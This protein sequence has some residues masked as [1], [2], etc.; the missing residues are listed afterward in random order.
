[1]KVEM[2]KNNN[3]KNRNKKFKNTNRS[4]NNINYINNAKNTN[5]NIKNKEKDKKKDKNKNNN[6]KNKNKNKK[7][8][9][10]N[11]SSNNN[12]FGNLKDGI[13]KRAKKEISRLDKNLSDIYGYNRKRDSLEEKQ[14]IK[15]SEENLSVENAK[16][17]NL[18]REIEKGSDSKYKKSFLVFFMFVL[19]LSITLQLKTINGVG[20]K[21]KVAALNGEMRNTLLMQREKNEMLLKEV[22]SKE[23]ELSEL[24]DK[25]SKN[26][27]KFEEKKNKLNEN[28]KKL[29]HTKIA[30]KGIVIKLRDG[31]DNKNTMKQDIS[32]LI[33]HDSDIIAIVNILR[34]AG[35]EAI[36]VNDQ[37]I[38]TKTPISCIGTVIKINE[39]KVGSP[40]IISAIGN[41][42]Y[43]ESA[44]TMPGG[45]IELLEQYGIDIS[46]EK[47]NNIEIP[48]YL[49]SSKMEY[50]K[51]EK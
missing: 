48:A 8:E 4:V 15:L 26:S 1:M 10:K 45:I 51:V 25:A 9:G 39:E 19:T 12:F 42:E 36:S 37:R 47:A 7:V 18:I 17:R 23:E 35:A 11:N 46:V 16:T 32:Q 31:S 38:V 49:S 40:Y 29:G 2:G 22:E 30:G 13:N 41:Q 27:I 24:R 43:L 34:N 20:N 6:N 50:A 33:V 21:S 14:K 3:R 44:L 28:K 5:T